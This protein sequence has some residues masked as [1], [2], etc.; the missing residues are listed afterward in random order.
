MKIF[1]NRLNVVKLLRAIEKAHL[2][3]ECV[4]LYNTDKQYDAAVRTMIEHPSSFQ[5]DTFLDSVQ[6]ARNPEIQYRS[7]TFYIQQ[8]PLQVGRLLQLLTPN[9]DHARIVHLLRKHNAEYGAL[10]LAVDYLKSVQKENLSVVNEALN[11][12][13]ITEEDYESLKVSVIIKLYFVS[14]LTN[15]HE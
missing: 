6:K 3:R 7:I 13:F 9:L 1:Y 4:Y 2:W 15:F 14:V 8:H 11:E 10:Y 5:H 12:I